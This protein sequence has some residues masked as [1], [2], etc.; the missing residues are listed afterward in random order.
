MEARLKNAR[1]AETIRDQ[2]SRTGLG[3]KL[4]KKVVHI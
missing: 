4:K 2:D 3:G 1:R